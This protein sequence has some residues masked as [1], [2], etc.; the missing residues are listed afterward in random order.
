VPEGAI[1]GNADSMLFHEPGSRWYDQTVA[2]VWFATVAEAEAAGYRRAGTA[3]PKADDD[4]V[5]GEADADAETDVAPDA[6]DADGVGVVV[7]EGAIKGNADSMKYHVP[8]S[9]WYAQTVAEV[10]F[11]TVADAVAAG[12][13]PAGGA[14]AQRMPEDQ[15]PSE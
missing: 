2:E 14:S 7:P 15:E 5:S 13:E 9:R 11:E 6:F 12:Y 8:G 1:K 10:W 3:A 4:D